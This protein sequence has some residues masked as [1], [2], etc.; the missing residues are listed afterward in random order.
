MAEGRVKDKAAGGS[1]EEAL[2]KISSKEWGEISVKLTRYAFI[3]LRKTSWETA[4]EIAQ[5]AI[6]RVLDRAHNAWNR[7]L[8]PELFDYLGSAVN[9]RVANELR[10]RARRGPSISLRDDARIH[11]DEEDDPVA[12]SRDRQDEDEPEMAPPPDGVLLVEATTALDLL[13]SV[14]NEAARAEA[15]FAALRARLEGDTL[16]IALLDRRRTE[17]EAR[18]ADDAKALG[19]DVNDIYVAKKR[20]LH[21]TRA[22][23][24]DLAAG[25]QS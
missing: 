3:R 13:T 22:V 8:Y 14:S 6:T 9:G 7:E 21:H 16:C 25:A 19:V 18:P 1:V 17:K 11:D 20:I 5:D 10:R 2:S 12:I 23:A 24:R 15:A 4:E